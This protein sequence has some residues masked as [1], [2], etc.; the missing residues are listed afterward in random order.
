MTIAG[1]STKRWYLL[2]LA[3]ATHAFAVAI[4]FSCMPVLFKEISADLDLSLLQ[5]G[6]VWGMLG[7][8][9]VF[10]SLI[11]GVLGDRF[12]V[13][14]ILGI[15]CILGGLAGASRG[16]ST[17]FVG[18]SVTVFVFGIIRAIIPINVHKAVSILFQ[19][20][21]LGTANGIVAMGMGIG[22]MLGPM[23]SA[24]VLSPLL[25]NWRNV[26]FLF[27][28][29]SMVAGMLWSLPWRMPQAGT[30]SP[31]HSGTVPFREAISKLLRV[32]AL[33]LVGLILMLRM[34]GITGM[35]GYLPLY[36]EERG[37]EIANADGTLAGFY[38]I[39][40]ICVIPLSLLSDRIG[41]RRTIMFIALITAVFGVGLLPIVDG[42]A[43][44]A[45]VLAAGMFWDVFMAVTITLV[46]E[47]KEVGPKYSGTALG[48]AFTFS[49]LGSFISPPLGNSLANLNPG[50]P[51]LF[52]ASLSVMAII[53]LFLL[54]IPDKKYN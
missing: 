48:L 54:R 42:L 10:V 49:Q 40:T 52:W 50:L 24:T 17:G 9:G 34:G 46:Q 28:A 47:T 29:V 3:V 38:A 36:L 16:L 18:L 1:Y 26:L 14:F 7:L 33:W 19:G 27:G 39:S 35:V 2:G 44:W 41:S 8:A 5:I 12:G 22:L 13:K 43:L 45:L 32:K 6:T 4:P 31:G 11:G 53:P 30:D 37:W 25:G 23:L 51:F 21:N 20:R 15:A